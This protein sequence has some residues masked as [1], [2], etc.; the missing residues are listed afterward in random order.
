MTPESTDI[1]PLQGT[2]FRCD[3]DGSLHAV[4][5]SVT[6]PNGLSWSLDDRTMYF[7]DTPTR[8]IYSYDFDASNGSVANKKVFFEVPEG[9]G[10]PDGHAQDE[11]GNLWV[12]LWGGWKVIR[13]SPQAEIT[14]EIKL[15]VRCPTVRVPDRSVLLTV[16]DL[17]CVTGRGNSRGGPLRR[18]RSRPRGAEASRVRPLSGCHLQVSD[19]RSRTQ[20][21][22]RQLQDGQAIRGLVLN[23][24]AIPLWP[25]MPCHSRGL[26]S[27]AS[28]STLPLLRLA[29][30]AAV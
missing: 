11:E 10:L 17:S 22:S 24:W 1:C 28:P 13:I 7:T 23:D 26:S 16:A 21:E 9:E 30:L 4:L 3:L 2:L 14:A 27:C 20:G 8:C 12:A 15:P 5:E 29:P 18:Q 19:R 6:I 25:L